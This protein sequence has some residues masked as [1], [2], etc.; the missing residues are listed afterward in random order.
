[1]LEDTCSK[2]VK[3]IVNSYIQKEGYKVIKIKR[4]SLYITVLFITVGCICN[5]LS[6]KAIELP[7]RLFNTNLTMSGST[8]FFI[9]VFLF[10]NMLSEIE[11]SRYANKVS[12]MNFVCV[13][14]SVLMLRFI[15]FLP[16]SDANISNMFSYMFSGSWKFFAASI[17]AY[18]ISISTQVKIF[19]LFRNSFGYRGRSFSHF[20]STCLSQF[21]DVVVFTFIGYFVGM[22]WYKLTNGLAMWRNIVCGQYLIQLVIIVISVPIF[23][24]VTKSHAI[25]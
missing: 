20:L 25:R 24:V 14:L 23:K 17:T 5:I 2:D 13:F 8:P 19:R 12:K 16:G 11:S 6:I 3:N 22:G 9:F 4:L 7:L 21:L 18:V 1:M 15:A 10:S